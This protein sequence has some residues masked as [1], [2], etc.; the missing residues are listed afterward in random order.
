MEKFDVFEI[1]GKKVF[2]GNFECYVRYYNN[3]LIAEDGYGFP[4]FLKKTKDGI[5]EMRRFTEKEL[6]IYNKMDSDF[7]FSADYFNRF[8]D[9]YIDWRDNKMKIWDQEKNSFEEYAA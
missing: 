8:E 1:N 7:V 5:K 4:H 6:K 3:R 2:Y 9:I